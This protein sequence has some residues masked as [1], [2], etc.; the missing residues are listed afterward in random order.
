M[1]RSGTLSVVV[2]IYD[3][4]GKKVGYASRSLEIS[5]GQLL[6]ISHN[7]FSLDKE[8][9]GSGF[10]AVFF[11]NSISHYEEV[12]ASTVITQANIDVGGYAWAK[13][14]FSFQYESSL[15]T[16]QKEQAIFFA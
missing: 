8:Y 11:S 6:E 16:L 1:R 10:G 13:A 15:V 2:K 4:K 12:G 5:D 14:G 3:S 9:T 7:N